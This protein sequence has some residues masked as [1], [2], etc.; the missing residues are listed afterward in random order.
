MQNLWIAAGPSHYVLDI[1]A[2]FFIAG[3]TVLCARRGFVECVFDFASTLVSFFIAVFLAKLVLSLTGGLFGL[4]GWLEGSFTKSFLKLDGFDAA[5]Y[6]EG[7]QD[8]LQ[9][10]NVAGVIANLAVKWFAKGKVAEGTTVAALL[11]EVTARLL[12]LLLTSAILFGLAKLILLL[13]KKILTGIID[14]ISLLDAANTALGAA[15]GFA[16]ALLI[17]GVVLSVLALIPSQAITG[18]LGNC[19]FLGW[20]YGHNPVIVLLGLLI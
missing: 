11:G 7:A 15:I 8:A 5:L 12:A 10:K 6:Q 20:L 4:Q 2:L 17:V 18:Y 3:L 13:T 9:N 14:K 16:Q 19:P 1:V